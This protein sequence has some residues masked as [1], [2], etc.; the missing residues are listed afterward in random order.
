MTNAQFFAGFVTFTEEILNEKNYF[1]AVI[2]SII[3]DGF[4]YDSRI[5]SRKY[6]ILSLSGTPGKWDFH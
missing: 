2:Y 4:E 1:C 3:N 5:E 6:S